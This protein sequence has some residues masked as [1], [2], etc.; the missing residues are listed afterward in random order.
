MLQ[1][2]TFYNIEFVDFVDK[3]VVVAY[4]RILS[5]YLSVEIPLRE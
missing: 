1:L 5:K 2:H 4:S 3:D